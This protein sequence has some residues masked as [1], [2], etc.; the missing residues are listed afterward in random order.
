MTHTATSHAV[1][2][3]GA[4]AVFSDIDYMTGNIDIESLKEKITE[5]TKAVIVVHMAGLASNMTEIKKL[6]KKHNIKL[7]EDCAHGL[8]SLYKKKH[9]G[10]F[11]DCG[12]F[13]LPYKT[14]HNGRGWYDNY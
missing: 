3:T 9:V 10:N 11:G 8:G 13:S 7:I 14:N 12:V 2:Y 1:E 6:C 5:K 4:K